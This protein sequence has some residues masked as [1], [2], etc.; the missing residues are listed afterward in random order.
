MPE[1]KPMKVTV[2]EVQKASALV[3]YK[4]KAG[5]KRVTIP[6]TEIHAGAVD[7][8]V[9]EAGIEYGVPFERLINI[10]VKPADYAEA[11]HIAGI[12]TAE[13]VGR[14]QQVV[15]GVLNAVLDIEFS[16]LLQIATAYIEEVKHA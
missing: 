11:L 2:I 9:L 3:E 5:L 1:Q 10:S 13:D 14:K 7:P 4:G 16:K 15:R 8:A 12:W 6:A